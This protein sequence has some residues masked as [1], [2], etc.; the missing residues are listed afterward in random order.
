MLQRGITNDDA[1]EAFVP[2]PHLQPS[3]YLL[4]GPGAYPRGKHQKGSGLTRKY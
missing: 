1:K 4:V 3:Q 2:E